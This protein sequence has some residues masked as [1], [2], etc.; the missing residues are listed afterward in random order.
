MIV[1]IVVVE[2]LPE[3]ILVRGEPV[4]GQATITFLRDNG[5]DAAL[6]HL[7]EIRLH[8]SLQLGPGLYS[9]QI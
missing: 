1:V 8:I 9:G 3:Q 2:R 6:Q 4:N 7:R 5:D